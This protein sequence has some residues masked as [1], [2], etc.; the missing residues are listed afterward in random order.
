MLRLAGW[1]WIAVSAIH[2]LGGIILYFEQWQAI[3]QAGWFNVIAPDPFAPI[4]DREDAFW[5]MFFTPF[6][7]LIGEL[8]LWLARKKLVFPVFV[9]VIVLGTVL[10]GLFLMP[11]SGIWLGLPPSLMM[12]Y[13]S[14]ITQHQHN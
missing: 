6:L 7:F 12:L 8:S 3:A 11:V 2:G 10:V 13:S 4:F 14:K 1:W 9:G 5:F